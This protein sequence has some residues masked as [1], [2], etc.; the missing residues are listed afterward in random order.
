V[1]SGSESESTVAVATLPEGASPPL[2][3]HDDLDDS[4]YVLEGTIVVRCGEQ[5]EVARPGSWVPFP[6]R[7]PHT[8]RVVG[9]EA[10]ILMVHSD[11]SFMDFVRDV[12]RPAHGDEVPTTGDG[13]PIDILMR[14][15]A[16]HGMTTVG[17]GMSDEEANNWLSSLG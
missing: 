17:P 16:E 6:R 5:V 13:P 1:L 3:V 11:D 14:S 12:G 7:V 10:R 15:M 4:F 2:H 9:G 8:F